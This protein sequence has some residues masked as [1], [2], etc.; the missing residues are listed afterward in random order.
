MSEVL[1]SAHLPHAIRSVISRALDGLS[2]EQQQ[3]VDIVAD[4]YFQNDNRWS[5]FQFV[6]GSLDRESLDLRDIIFFVPESG[7]P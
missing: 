1:I 3:V 4:A 2:L 5:T 7:R 6:E